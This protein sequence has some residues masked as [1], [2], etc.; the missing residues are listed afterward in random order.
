[1]SFETPVPG[2]VAALA[3]LREIAR[4]L[5]G[6]ILLCGHSK[7][8]NLAFYSA[9]SAEEL[10]G[11]IRGAWSFDGPGLDD[12]MVASEAYAH[13]EPR[14][15]TVLP[16]GSIIGVLKTQQVNHRLVLSV[17]RGIRQHDVF[18]W[19]TQGTDFVA[20]E[21]SSMSSRFTDRTLDA[22]L[23]EC[24]PEQRRACVDVLF[25]LLDATEAQ[26]VT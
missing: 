17:A 5:P 20:A 11:R 2:Q 16:Q 25:D 12:A 4:Q 7:G 23:Q 19:Q 21:K 14:L 8:G 26:T 9:V 6:D 24:T 22:F 18:S 1:M 13:I 15:H 3:Y 10:D